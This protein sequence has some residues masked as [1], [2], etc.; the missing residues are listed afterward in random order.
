MSAN[1]RLRSVVGVVTAGVFLI[2]VLVAASIAG[3][4]SVPVIIGGHAPETPA[5]S[6]DRVVWA[7][8]RYGSYD[9]FVYDDS[10]GMT[11]RLTTS[12]S[13][14]IQPAIDGD[15]VVYVGYGDTGADIYAHDLGSG[16]TRVVCSAAL[17]QVN[18]SI[19][20]DRVVWEDYRNGYNPGIYSFDLQAGT[21][22]RIDS[23]YAV[24][25][26]RPRIVG[27]IVVWEDYPSG[28]AGHADVRMYDFATSAK[29]TIAGTAVHERAPSTDG[30]Y[31]VWA[32]SA[33]GGSDIMGFDTQEDEYFTVRMQPGEQALPAI[34]D[35]MVY[36]L[37]NSGDRR[38][39]VDAYEIS[40]G[41]FAPF[42][43]YGVSSLTGFVASG[44]SRAWLERVGEQWQIRAQLAPAAAPTAS[45]AVML[46]D[47]PA[48]TPFRLAQLAIGDDR[49]VPEIE[50]LSVDP[51]ETLVD[52]EI[53]VVVYFS[54]PLDPASVTA[55]AVSLRDSSTGAVVDTSIRYSALA[56]AISVDPDAVLAQGSYTLSI[57]DDIADAAGNLL[58]DETQ[59]TFSTITLLAD[60]VSPNSANHVEARVDGPSDITVVWDPASDDVGVAGYDIYRYTAPISTTNFASATLVASA[61]GAATST[62]FSRVVDAGS[63][64]NDDLATKYSTY[65][66]A[67]ITRDAAGNTSR[68]SANA[69]PNPHGTYVFGG[70]TNNC[71]LC[72][73]VHGVPEGGAGALGARNAEACYECHGDTDSSTGYGFASTMNIQGR[74]YDYTDQT[75]GSQ[76][77]NTYMMSIQQECD[78]CHTPHKKSYSSDSALSYG[79]LLKMDDGSGGLTYSTDA[80]PLGKELC[81]SCH[82]ATSLTYMTGVGG[83][84]AYANSAGDHNEG[85]FDAA[86]MAHSESNVAPTAESALPNGG[87]DPANSC[88]AC[89]NE[90]ASA[91]D[92]LIDY[93]QS[94]TVAITYEQSGLCYECHSSA[95]AEAGVPNTWNSRDIKTEFA[96]TS[97]H[98]VAVDVGG[99]GAPVPE[100][101]TWTQTTQADFASD[102]LVAAVAVAGGTG[103]SGS[104]ELAPSGGG[105]ENSGSV[106]GGPISVAGGTLNAWTE[107]R[108][109]GA[110]PAGSTLYFDLLDGADESVLAADITLA[111]SP[112]PLA[113]IDKTAHPTLK[114]R[115][116]FSGNGTVAPSVSDDFADNS[117]DTSLWTDYP[118]L[119]GATPAA[120]YPQETSGQLT[121]RAEGVDFWNT[122]D[123]GDF[124]YVQPSTATWIAGSDWDMQVYVPSY[125][126][127]AG[128]AW[129][130]AGL[131]VRTGTTVANA[132][133]GGAKMAG[134]YVTDTNG[135]SFQYRLNVGAN[136]AGTGA[137][138]DPKDDAPLWL[139]IERRANVLTGYVST[140]G[141]DWTSIGSQ[142]VSL[143]GVVLVGTCLT[144][145]VNGGYSTAT[146]DDF[147]VS[148]IT[149]TP[150]TVTPQ[151]DDWSVEYVW[152]PLPS[153][154][155]AGELTCYSCH[156]TH[157]IETGTAGAVWQA[158]RVSNPDDT[159]QNYAGGDFDSFCLACH[160]SGAPSKTVDDSTLVPYTPRMTD[161]SAYDFFPGWDKTAVGWSTSGHANSGI[162]NM[163]PG[164]QTCHDPHG[165]DNPRLTALTA[166]NTGLPSHM[167]AQRNN[168]STYAEEELC[169][170]CHTNATSPNCTANG[171]HQAALRTI[172][173]ET[174]FGQTYAHPIS[175]SGRHSDTEGAAD[176]GTANRHAECVD[177]HDP[178]GTQPGSHT[179]GEAL[180]GPAL[181]GATG[182]RPTSWNGNWGTP[183]TWVSERIDGGT[184]DVEAYVCFKCH[185]SYTTLPTTGGS[186]GYGATDV[187]RDFNPDNAS[188]HNVIFDDTGSAPWPKTTHN[189]GGTNYTWGFPTNNVF[190]AGW[191]S[192]SMVTCSDCHTYDQNDANTPDGPHGSSVKYII[193]SDYTT[194]WRSTDAEIDK[195]ITGGLGFPTTLICAKCHDLMDSSENWSNNVHDEHEGRGTGDGGGVCTDCH[196]GV[197][198]GWSRPRL[199]GYWS[200]PAP[201]QVRNSDGLREIELK[202][203]TPT[204]WQKSDCY[205]SCSLSRHPDQPTAWP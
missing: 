167:Q 88:N 102:T 202:S 180:A 198:H 106:T 10:S 44:D 32:Q 94:G 24:Y 4:A 90:H 114:V 155:G 17:D 52:P 193:D 15:T 152:T 116:R 98:P 29:T 80:D 5:V 131:M 113:A 149:G 124:V 30:R 31:V 169:F 79:S 165:S 177:C 153:A 73:S 134:M 81:F 35:G 93:R 160:D 74:M 109:T 190:K 63:P 65:Y 100:V 37:D 173:L 97:A 45:F 57:T 9:I 175:T 58:G 138:A 188:G 159:T 22:M 151:V 105:Y 11:T 135:V 136:A 195:D 3:A 139:K 62:T 19:S 91:V 51:G 83:A 121:L 53:T 7:D 6:G 36:W 42:D 34:A 192:T 77:R 39:H 14:E 33:D 137:Q 71:T 147:A 187:A 118:T 25:K 64:S 128:N 2:S 204:S 61:G 123:E 59:V 66:Y 95:G 133:N 164:C 185:S 55:D 141:T 132:L 178:H 99:V 101:A 20:G 156:N 196:V 21:E 85:N 157:Y 18:P 203:Y 27:D 171:C 158:G 119:G 194:E 191:S 49:V 189:V 26:I 86:G 70:N 170:A 205:A 96:R 199:L 28:K 47:T 89:H 69:N 129:M 112:Y 145:H 78:A 50:S 46:P 148:G 162:Q 197:P 92:N 43:S 172:D 183:T 130:K 38:T 84:S 48:W 186:G 110:A 161:M 23:G 75:A 127:S 111:M 108:L 76:H 12:D 163:D 143:D 60:T 182:I 8:N 13:D 56:R 166:F 103:V 184:T 87:F 68:L 154:A 107:L 41:D 150:S 200:D 54:E 16:T 67:I 40:S 168:S 144:S 117:F 140:N 104:V 82:G 142:T 125:V 120:G 181:Y 115:A 179:V 126:N 122:N 1:L 146:F 72:H 201:Y 174:A 176:M